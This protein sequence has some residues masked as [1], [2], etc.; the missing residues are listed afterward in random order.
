MERS[1][2]DAVFTEWVF[3]WWR[4]ETTARPIGGDGE[5]ERDTHKLQIVIHHDLSVVSKMIVSTWTSRANANDTRHPVSD[6]RHHDIV[7]SV[8]SMILQEVGR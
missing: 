4:C 5:T 6:L 8:R 3:W 2:Y 1:T 7:G